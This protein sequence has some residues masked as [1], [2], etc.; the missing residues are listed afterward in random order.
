MYSRNER[1]FN[2]FLLKDKIEG[3]FY[4]KMYLE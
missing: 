2:C 1:D 3:I 4:G